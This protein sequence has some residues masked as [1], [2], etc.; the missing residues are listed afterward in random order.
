MAKITD[1]QYIA[2]ACGVTLKDKVIEGIAKKTQ[3]EFDIDWVITELALIETPKSRDIIKA[4]N[5]AKSTPKAQCGA[6]KKGFIYSL[7]RS[8]FRDMEASDVA[9]NVPIMLPKAMC[10]C[11]NCG[12]TPGSL[13]KSLSYMNLTMV[14]WQWVILYDFAIYHLQHS[15]APNDFNPTELWPSLEIYPEL[16]QQQMNVMNEI[17]KY[18]QSRAQIQTHDLTPLIQKNIRGIA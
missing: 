13:Q 3:N 10:Y 14:G 4:I 5:K 16:T 8:V 7:N 9:I 2:T 18:A 11:P 12:K 17:W 1:V 6:C 15:I